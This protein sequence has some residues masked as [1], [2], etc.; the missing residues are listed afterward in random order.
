MASEVVGSKPIG[1]SNVHQHLKANELCNCRR[2]TKGSAG[3]S[4]TGVAQ[5]RPAWYGYA[6]GVGLVPGAG[7]KRLSPM[8]SMRG[9]SQ[10][11]SRK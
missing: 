10:G 3:G 9:F 6:Y 1:H 2:G 11:S 8:P 7:K 5:L 4:M